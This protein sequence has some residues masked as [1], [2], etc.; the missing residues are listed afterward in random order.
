MTQLF[1]FFSRMQNGNK[2]YV[3]APV[4]FCNTHTLVI[5]EAESWLI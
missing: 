5:D 3:D 2:N 4:Y 1:L